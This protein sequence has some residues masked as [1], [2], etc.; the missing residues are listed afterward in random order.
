MSLEK[1]SI[2]WS[3]K[4]LKGMVVNGKINFD[5]IV[6]R[7]YVWERSRKSALIESMIIGYPIP[8]VF[9]KRTDDGTGKRGGNVYAILDGKQR[10][11]TIKE[12]LN[13]EFALTALEPVSYM[14]DEIGEE[15]TANISDKKFSELPEALQNYLNTITISVTYFDN[16]TR[17]EER[18][19][20]KR[21][22]AGK[23]LSTKSRLLAS[24]KDIEGLL[25]I[26]SHKLFEEMMTDKS[27][28]NKNQ[29]A[30]VMKA[31]CMMNQNIDNVSFES[32]TF[33][34]LL[35]RTEVAEAEKLAMIEVF[36]LIV[37]THSALIENKEKKVAKKLYTETHMISLIPFFKKAVESD[38]DESMM[39][40]WLVEFFGTKDTASVSEEYNDACVG[41]SA[42]N[43]NIIARHDALAESYA[44][45][46]RTDEDDIDDIDDDI[47]DDVEDDIEFEEEDSEDEEEFKSMSYSEEYDSLVNEMMAGMKYNN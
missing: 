7:S 17:E 30:L 12:Y 1:A 21:L 36:N 47:E 24:C 15:C 22:N 19:M 4:Q 32:K 27:R 13:D 45:F 11:S 26:G 37:R 44:E 43:V 38:I 3:A 46:F 14:D 10:L 9:A 25:D 2:V 5:H 8:S 16:L 23:P 42:K 39:A 33:N 31:W 6:Q 40:N 41:G 18:E 29:V 34:P 35:E 20:F 28:D